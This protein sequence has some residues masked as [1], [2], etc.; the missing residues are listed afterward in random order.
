M[1]IIEHNVM[2]RRDLISI[3][4]LVLLPAAFAA[5]QDSTSPSWPAPPERARIRYVGTLNAESEFESEGGFFGNL[6]GTLFGGHRSSV[7]LVQPVG[8][9]VSRDGRIYV[10]DPGIRGVH[11]LQPE[12]KKI[13]L[14]TGTD[15]DT[16]SAPAGCAVDADGNVYVADAD[17]RTVYVLDQ[18]GDLRRKITTG[19]SRPTGVQVSGDTVFVADAG[20]HRI[21]LF[22]REG[23][24]LSDFGGRGAGNAEFNYPVQLAVR[25]SLFVVDALNYRVQV[26]DR[27]GAFGSTFGSLG[28]VAGRFAAPKAVAL[29]SDGN[30]YVSDGLMDNIQIFDRAGRLLLIFGRGGTANGEFTMPSGIAITADDTIYVV[31]S[32]NRRIQIF[33]Y[34]R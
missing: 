31:D 30:I 28:N 16:F 32:L 13:D 19:L 29:D 21:F 2:R 8:I 15:E 5:A 22:D 24:P 25:D 27:G 7:W 26:F 33:R 11:V 9:A 1:R 10:A 4:T 34:L 3:L 20:Q 6:L 14:W 17:R 23:K 18:D 12:E